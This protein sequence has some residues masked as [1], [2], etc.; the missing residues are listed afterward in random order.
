M[1]LVVLVD[2]ALGKPE[3]LARLGDY[4]ENV[5]ESLGLPQRDPAIVN[6]DPVIG[7]EGAHTRPGVVDDRRTSLTR[8][9]RRFGRA[10]SRHTRPCPTTAQVLSYYVPTMS[11]LETLAWGYGLVEGPRVDDAGN[12]YFSDVHNGG[13]FRRTPDGTIDTVVPK[14]R[15]VGGI[16]L[17][18]DGGLVI[19]GRNICHVVDGTTRIVFAP[20]A[21]GLNDVFVDAR[22]RVI[23]GT[24]RS[25]PFSTDGPRTAGECWRIDAEGDATELYGDIALTNGI[26]FSPDGTVLYHSD[27]TRG[28]WAHDYDDGAVSGGRLYLQL[29]DLM[30]DGLA[31]DEA[32]TVWVAD[33]SGSGALRGFAPDSS[34]VARIEVPARMVTS[35]CFGGPDRRDLYIVTGDNTEVA[36]RGGTI[37]RT[38]ADV[39]GCAVPLAT[40]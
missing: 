33:V 4:A 14:R 27:T 24:M 19:S 31:V 26:G 7:N 25:D 40:V 21:P 3:E 10:A 13:V 39:A 17:H 35:V 37:H 5:I 30:P 9:R 15:G 16:A 6:L 8:T 1:A 29:D 32:G 23:C 28:V 36:A 2:G 11:N 22:G 20:D 38:R 12:L 34:E 18:A